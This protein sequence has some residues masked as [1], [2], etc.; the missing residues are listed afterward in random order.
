MRDQQSGVLMY[1][2]DVLDLIDE[3]VLE[4]DFGEGESGPPGF[5]APFEPAPRQAVLQRLVERLEGLV[6][7]LADRLADRRDDQRVEDIDERPRIAPDRALRRP[8]QSGRQ[9]LPQPRVARRVR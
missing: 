2:K 3:R 7:R 5:P 4:H 1:Q 8:L 6:D 9:Y